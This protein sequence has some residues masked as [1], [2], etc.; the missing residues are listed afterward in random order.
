MFDPAKVAE[1]IFRTLRSFDYSVALFDDEGSQVF[2]PSDARRFFTPKNVITVSLYEDGEN[3][4]LYIYLSRKVKIG[5]VQGLLNTLRECATKFGINYSV[6]KYRREISPKDFANGNAAVLESRKLTGSTKSS[7]LKLEGARM[8]VRHD[9]AVDD[10]KM[11]ARGRNVRKV[12]VEN[13]EGERFLMPT[14]NMMAGRAMTRHVS[15]GGEFH[16]EVGG[17]L[18]ELAAQQQHMKTCESYCRKNKK[19]IDESAMQ[20]IEVCNTRAKRLRNVFEALYRNYDRGLKELAQENDNILLE[21]DL[22]EEKINTLKS[23]LK[24]EDEDVVDR[25]TC[26]SIVRVLGESDLLEGR[27]AKVDM[28]RLGALGCEV[29]APAWEAFKANPPSI[30]FIRDTAP[31]LSSC[32]S[33]D[34]ACL[35]LISNQCAYDAFANML[36]KVA[37]LLEDGKEDSLLK[38]IA[39]RAIQAAKSHANVGDAKP[40][41]KTPSKNKEQEVA[42]ARKDDLRNG[43]IV[44]E[45]VNALQNWFD[46]MSEE[47]IFETEYTA[48]AHVQ[49]AANKAESL[50]YKF[51]HAEH[52]NYQVDAD[53]RRTDHYEHPTKGGKITIQ[54]GAEKAT[55]GGSH[56]G[57]VQQVQHAADSAP[58]NEDDWGSSYPKSRFSDDD[59]DSAIDDAHTTIEDDFNVDDFLV[60]DGSD[61]HYG[62]STLTA[63]DKQIHASEL[64]GSLEHYLEGELH[65]E[66]GSQVDIGDQDGFGDIKPIARKLLPRV[67]ERLTSEGY[68]IDGMEEFESDEEGDALDAEDGIHFDDRML[69]DEE[70]DEKQIA[71]LAA[72]AMAARPTNH[73][74]GDRDSSVKK[75]SEMA[76]DPDEDLTDDVEDDGVEDKKEMLL[77]GDD[78]SSEDIL[79]PVNPEK[80]FKRDVAADTDGQRGEKEDNEAF[81]NRL[82][83]L[84][85]IKATQAP[86]APQP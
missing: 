43:I 59:L 36:S 38:N 7:Y 46:S 64:L 23:K 16:D 84:A 34:A 55:V 35:S 33:L 72:R 77:S 74:Y 5:E 58:L 50:G 85:G 4:F 79:Q 17:K 73:N 63:E 20:L 18:T 25:P 27:P 82:K 12:F 21:D 19:K 3:S 26:E 32:G 45:S 62:D 41:V 6:R 56:A 48:P 40:L 66:I 60:M 24:L 8:I 42:E 61:F 80:D 69:E 10:S 29:E 65:N 68:V 71:D 37:Q 44:T 76:S 54:H 52:A 9:G 22:M 70:L 57:H 53:K 75:E 2:E 31:N 51:S 86:R 39:H 14:Q 47:A 78:L 67:A 1:E 83:G 15:K 49:S 13:S 11:G 81:I 28:V 30:Q